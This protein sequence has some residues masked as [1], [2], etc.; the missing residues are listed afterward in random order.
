MNVEESF[1]FQTEQSTLTFKRNFFSFLFFALFF[2]YFEVMP[3]YKVIPITRER[4]TLCDV[5]VYD[6]DTNRKVYRKKPET[7]A[8]CSNSTAG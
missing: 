5:C 6:T 3:S 7:F 8:E 1:I 4:G 2:Y